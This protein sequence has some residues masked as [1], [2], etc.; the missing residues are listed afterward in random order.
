M[1]KGDG[2]D[3]QDIDL[4]ASCD[5]AYSEGAGAWDSEGVAGGLAVSCACVA[6]P[7][8]VCAW[9]SAGCWEGSAKFEPSD[10]GSSA[11]ASQSC[12]SCPKVRNGTLPASASLES[13][14]GGGPGR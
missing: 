10:S 13:G 3:H 9:F 14:G 8:A 1:A 6:G 2:P 12:L 5:K 7:W 4:S 11:L